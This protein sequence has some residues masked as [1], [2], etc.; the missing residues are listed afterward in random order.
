[1][2]IIYLPFFLIYVFIIFFFLQPANNNLLLNSLLDN[3]SNNKNDIVKPTMINKT[4]KRKNLP[5]G[6]RRILEKQ[7]N[8]VIEAYKLLKSRKS[9][10][11]G[12]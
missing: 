12:V 7:Q 3:K 5:A 2:N 11:V 8:E 4:G 1:M 10:G 6:E 9:M